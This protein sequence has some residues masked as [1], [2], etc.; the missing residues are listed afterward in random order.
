LIKEEPLPTR[1]PSKKRDVRRTGD[2]E[3]PLGPDDFLGLNNK[4]ATKR[5]PKELAAEAGDPPRGNLRARQE[6]RS[7]EDDSI[8]IA[9]ALV[10][11][12][13]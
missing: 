13:A 5:M 8:E 10:S 4:P 11:E 12:I 9:S 7:S 3:P 2:S 6:F 1:K